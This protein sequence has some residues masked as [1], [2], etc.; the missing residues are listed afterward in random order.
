M[1]E[2]VTLHASKHLVTVLMTKLLEY[3][4]RWI[5]VSLGL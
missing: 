3:L 1:Q 5:H 2:R 4:D